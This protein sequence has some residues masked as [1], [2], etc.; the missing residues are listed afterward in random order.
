MEYTLQN[1]LLHKQDKRLAWEKR[2]AKEHKAEHIME[3]YT[4]VYNGHSS[5]V[6]W[7]QS[8]E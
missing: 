5:G 7:Q 4:N 3:Y 6:S 1:P 8:N 2:V